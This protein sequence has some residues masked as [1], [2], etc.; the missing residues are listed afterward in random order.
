MGIKNQELVPNVV[1]TFEYLRDPEAVLLQVASF[2]INS[3][4][5]MVKDKFGNG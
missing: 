5:E 3:N 2:G 1:T 4:W